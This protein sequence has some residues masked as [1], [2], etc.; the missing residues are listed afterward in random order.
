MSLVEEDRL[1]K[2][3]FCHTA[4]NYIAVIMHKSVLFMKYCCN[5]YS[6]CHIEYFCVL[7]VDLLSYKPNREWNLLSATARK[8]L[9]DYRYNA[10]F[11][12]IQ[13]SFVM[14]RHSSL[15]EATMGVSALSKKFIIHINIGLL[16]RT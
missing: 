16:E 13:Y 5:G 1:V 10:T 12:W 6:L 11:P 3:T 4:T 9:D 8:H 7:K 15:Y 2:A 14:Q